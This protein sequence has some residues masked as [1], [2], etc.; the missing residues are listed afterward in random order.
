MRTTK[1]LG[2]FIWLLC[3]TWFL[4]VQNTVSANDS[5][6]KTTST[7]TSFTFGILK[8]NS[9]CAQ[10]Y[11]WVVYK[12]RILIATAKTEEQKK[13]YRSSLATFT[14]R[15]KT[16][17]T[18]AAW[19]GST[20]NTNTTT[21]ST[22]LPKNPTITTIPTVTENVS[23]DNWI[24]VEANTGILANYSSNVRGYVDNLT[25]Q[26]K[27]NFQSILQEMI[28]NGLLTTLDKATMRQKIVLY[29]TED[30]KTLNGKT[31]V[32]QWLDP[33]TN[34]VTKSNLVGILFKINVCTDTTIYSYLKKSV[35]EIITHELWHVYNFLHDKNADIFSSIC[36]NGE[37]LKPTCNRQSFVSDYA[38]LNTD[39]D[40][41]ET[42]TNRYRLTLPTT[43]NAQLL[44][45]KN[46]FNQIQPR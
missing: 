24:F 34:K 15:W 42:F 44:T 26:F 36:W 2:Y 31:T 7:S 46:Y 40:Y 19:T 21:G 3:A 4:F 23:L 9:L 32:E 18:R 5:E 37:T 29:Y 12:Y 10:N 41:A 35:P 38:M 27:I 43:T 30:C 25:F 45:K 28:T 6:M 22:T 33:T 13:A 17:C 1:I 11:T 20:T 16:L 39:E 8:A 14:T